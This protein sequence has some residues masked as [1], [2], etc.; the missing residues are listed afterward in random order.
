MLSSAITIGFLLNH[1][2]MMWWAVAAAAPVIIHLWNRR[3]HREAPWAA[4][5]YLLAAMRKNSR[6]IQVEQWILL[7]IRTLLVFLVVFALSEPVLERA[8][9][10][11]RSGERTHV[12]LVLDG[13]YSMGYKPTDENLFG[14]AKELATR[15]VDQRDQGDGYT[16]VLMSSPPRVVVG[17]P[18]FEKSD[19][20]EEIKSLKLPHGSG[21]LPATLTKVEE[22]L[23]TV[24]N[25]HPE[26]REEVYII[27]DLGRNSWLPELRTPDAKAEFFA[28]SKRLGERSNVHVI[29]LG[30]F[31]GENM[32]VTN[33]QLA[34]NL[35]KADP[36]PT[37]SQELMLEATVQNYGRQTRARQLVELY[38]DDRRAGETYVDLEPSRSS[39]VTFPYRFDVPGEHA[40]EVR[41]AG[42]L[43]DIDNHRWLTMPI[44]DQIRILCINGDPSDESNSSAIN[45]VVNAISPQVDQSANKALKIQKERETALLELDLSQYECIFLVNVGQFTASEAKVL[46]GYLQQGGGVVFFLGDQVQPDSYNRHLRVHGKEGVAVLPAEVEGRAP[47]GPHLL[48]PLDYKHPLVSDFRGHE[49]AGLLQSIVSRYFKLSVP[50][51][52][53]ATVA[54][55]LDNK[56]P[57]IVEEAIGNGRSIV[58]AT[59][60]NQP[61]SIFGKSPAWLP[62]MQKMLVYSVHGQFAERNILVGQPLGESVRTL[63]TG[64]DVTIRT[65]AGETDTV[66]LKPSGDASQW[67]YDATTQ[68]GIYSASLGSPLNRTETFAVN[69]DT[70]ES[71]LTRMT[72]EELNAD[73]WPGVRYHY[74][75]ELENPSGGATDAIGGRSNLHHLVLWTVLCLMLL[76]TMLAWMFGRRTA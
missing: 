54:L 40:V 51:N 33:L 62:I 55:E 14:W 28:R 66:R 57:A 24:Q 44:K 63:A 58:V 42:D 73:I 13:S 47:D 31:S 21:D 50:E 41:I 36:M 34:S 17:T 70:A 9:L 2:A 6:R 32:A 11:F 60:P 74:Q 48:N 52:S 71:D 10:T 65:P 7:A 37:V 56:D 30:Q 43:L 4:M 64:V 59:L 39:A 46:A 12:V 20:I 16:L 38:V 72:P 22:L 8:G 49:K 75:R 5:Q 3:K 76:E 25:D 23:K 35:Q 27:S 15:I 69:V 68:S 1:W 61:W 19:F 45:Y 67:R 18:A 29:D 26:L 53:R